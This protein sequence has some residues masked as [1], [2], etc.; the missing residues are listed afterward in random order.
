MTVSTAMRASAP[1]LVVLALLALWQFGA[2]LMQ[3]EYWPGLQ[4]IF[5]A[6][7]AVLKSGELWPDLAG[8][9]RRLAIGFSI[10]VLIGVPLGL[11]TGR[12]VL[13]DSLVSP[14]LGMI[15]PVPKAALLPL[16]MLWFGAGDLSKIFIIVTTVS[17]PLIYHA[18]HGAQA[19]DTKLLW[20][21]RAM[22][23]SP[24]R[25][26]AKIVLPA[27][28]PEILIGMRVAIVLGVIVML[29]SEM[30]VRQAGLGNLLFTSLDMGQYPAGYAIILVIA[31]IGFGLDFLFE[32]LRLRLTRW[33]PR[34]A[35]DYEP[36]AT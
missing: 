32:R 19:V 3:Q 8:S 29:T 20:S 23:V 5:P 7:G 12:S 17:L 24:A 13:V 27:A 16:V 33:A 30:F 1:L 21:A 34:R 11:A 6:L 26:I 15:Y 2:V 22:G 4:E 14:L 35:D 9:L 28:L 31:F 10:G 25:E 36:G 18:Q